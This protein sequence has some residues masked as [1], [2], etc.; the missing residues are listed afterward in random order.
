[1]NN[2]LKDLEKLLL[3]NH[4]KKAKKVLSE[5]VLNNDKS[6]VDFIFEKIKE[7]TMQDGLIIS[8]CVKTYF[9]LKRKSLSD[10]SP[11]FDFDTLEYNINESL[12]EVLG[13][14]K[15]IPSIEDQ[16]KII[17]K[18]FYFGEGIPSYATDPRY[19]L[20]AACAGW[21]ENITRKFLEHCLTINDA[22]LKYVTQNSLKRKY[23]KLR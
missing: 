10:I 19:G 6:I 5:F 23:V 13:Y 20:A 22:P 8:Y 4:D 11:M 16:K 21:D 9:R 15:M 17:D 3:S 14:D 12:L 1:M 2:K 7:D 18:Y